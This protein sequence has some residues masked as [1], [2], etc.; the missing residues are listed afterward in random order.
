MPFYRALWS[1]GFFKEP[2]VVPKDFGDLHFSRAWEEF[3]ASSGY[4]AS[5]CCCCSELLRLSWQDLPMGSLGLLL[6]VPQNTS[7]D[8]RS[9]FHS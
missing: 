9:H 3:Q 1:G 4:V 2:T 7:G 8:C 6:P 5:D